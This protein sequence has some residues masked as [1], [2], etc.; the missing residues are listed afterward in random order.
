MSVRGLYFQIVGDG[1]I[2]LKMKWIANESAA[3]VSGSK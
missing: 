2:I 3:P 1:E